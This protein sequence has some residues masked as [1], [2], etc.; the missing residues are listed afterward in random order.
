MAAYLL[1]DNPSWTTQKI[2]EA[3]NATEEKTVR[4]KQPVPVLITYNTAWVDEAGKL[5]FAEDI[6]GHD[7]KL[8]KRMF[9]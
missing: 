9:N 3:M 8:Y 7:T 5:H 4:L 1:K 2:D 6:Y